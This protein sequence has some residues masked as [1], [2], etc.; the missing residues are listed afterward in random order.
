MEHRC[1]L[2]AAA[3]RNPFIDC[4]TIERWLRN[5]KCLIK[6]STSISFLK[7]LNVIH[8]FDDDYALKHPHIK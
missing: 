4:A 7:A 8:T 1:S 5:G 2:S 3:D 6:K